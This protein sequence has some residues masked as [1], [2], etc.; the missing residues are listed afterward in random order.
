MM[1]LKKTKGEEN[2]MIHVIATIELNEGTRDAFL[3]IFKSNIPAVKA[4]NGCHRY[5]PTVDFDSGFP[6]QV[7]P[8]ENI[9][10]ILESWED[11]DALKAHA[12]APHMAAY[13]EKVQ[14]MVINV[15]LQVLEPA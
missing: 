14:D 6:I 11:M 10:T 1:R 8:R 12:K 7:G 15:S 4:E 2:T 5:E 13:R 9:V 3:E